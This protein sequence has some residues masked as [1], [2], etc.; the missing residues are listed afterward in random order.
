MISG[1][2]EAT[3]FLFLSR[4]DRRNILEHRV[5]YGEERRVGAF[6][7]RAWRTAREGL[8]GCLG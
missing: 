3:S 4:F 6:H 7:V 2:M 5:R 8:A 1:M